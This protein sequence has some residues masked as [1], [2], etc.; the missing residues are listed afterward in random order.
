MILTGG[1]RSTG[2]ETCHSAT[3]ST[4]NPIWID[5][6]PNLVLR[7]VRPATDHLGHG[8]GHE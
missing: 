6:E 3:L 4:T 1:N 7:S 8:T 2:R 5:L